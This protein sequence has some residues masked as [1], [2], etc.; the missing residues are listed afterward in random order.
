[1]QNKGREQMKT[2]KK[3]STI[4]KKKL[5]RPPGTGKGRTIPGTKEHFKADYDGQDPKKIIYPKENPDIEETLP[6]PDDEAAGHQ[7]P[8]PSKDPTFRRMWMQFIDSI[9]RRENFTMGHLNP[10]E[11]LCDLYVEYESLRKFIRKRGRSY[12][13][14]GRAGKIW[15]LYPEVGQLNTVQ[16][17]INIY[18]KQLG[19]LLKKD[20]SSE[21]GGEKENWD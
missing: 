14:Y 5:G 17:Q 20:T 8:P 21:S 12:L 3:K 2:Q 4:S 18:M 1:M 13:V 10:L 6:E 15:K 19:L 16:H 7:F 11:I 9:A